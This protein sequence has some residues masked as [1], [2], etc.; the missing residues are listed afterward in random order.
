[1]FDLFGNGVQRL[2]H[3]Q[4]LALARS[5]REVPTHF[6]ARSGPLVRSLVCSVGKDIRFLAMQ[7]PAQGMGAEDVDRVRRLIKKVT[8]NRT[9]LLV[10]HNIGVVASIADTITVLQ[11]GAT[12]AGRVPVQRRMK[13]TYHGQQGL[14]RVRH[15]LV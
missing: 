14:V 1:V 9:V 2:A 6:L 3:V 7:Q 15:Q 13:F 5:H 12:L 10:E 11:R 8:A 4:Q